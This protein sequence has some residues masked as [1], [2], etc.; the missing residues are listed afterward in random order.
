MNV[1]E[2]DYE[3]ELS[4]IIN[5]LKSNRFQIDQFKKKPFRKGIRY[6]ITIT[7]TAIPSNDAKPSYGKKNKKDDKQTVKKPIKK[8]KVVIPTKAVNA[9]QNDDKP[10]PP[11]RPPMAEITSIGKV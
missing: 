1:K 3:L 2:S 6:T 9:S 11:V 7:D 5:G 8:E 10:L 4:D